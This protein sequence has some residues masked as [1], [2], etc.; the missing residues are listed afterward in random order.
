[1]SEVLAA[2]VAW[3]I[4]ATALVIATTTAL[5][6]A[7]VRAPEVRLRAWQATAL[8]AF[9]AALPGRGLLVRP[10]AVEALTID[11]VSGPSHAAATLGPG[12][13]GLVLATLGIVA[14]VRLLILV[15][16]WSRL[17]RSANH[18]TQPA[19]PLFDRAAEELGVTARLVVVD[20]AAPFTFGRRSPIV[21]VDRAVLADDRTAR[22]V[23]LHELSHVAR[24]DC[25]A[26]VVEAIASC[27]LWF[28]PAAWWVA[29]ELR[30]AREEVV[31]RMAAGLLGSRREY[32]QTLLEVALRTPAGTSAVPALLHRRHLARRVRA[33]ASEVHMSRRHTVCALTL[34]AFALT[35]AAYAGAATA[36]VRP[37]STSTAPDAAE[38]PVPTK[39]V[40]AVYPQEAKDKHI[41]GDVELDVTVGTD[42]HVKDVAVRKSIPELDAAAVAA[43]RQWEFKPGRA[44][45]KPVDVV[46]T[47]TI[48]FTLK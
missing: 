30:A 1:M 36:P 47:V 10:Q 11:V 12:A 39:K 14:S 38:K 37:V 13:A 46:C 41:E 42:G 5:A 3:S 4:Q 44:K 23:F 8:V 2:I 43:I 22:A 6:C 16:G 29:R 25:T 24:G 21:V 34:L 40:N 27:V 48:A 32:L 7:R 19:A 28:H 18:G 9:A 26:V 17:R 45:G 31:D 33:L 15:A 20:G 35:L